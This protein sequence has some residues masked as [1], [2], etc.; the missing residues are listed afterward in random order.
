MIRYESIDPGYRVY[1]ENKPIGKIK[2]VK[3][4]YRYV[5]NG[6]SEKQG[7][8]VFASLGACKQSLED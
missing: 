8:E 2:I 1:L 6:Y 5:P 7:G 4:G 3:D